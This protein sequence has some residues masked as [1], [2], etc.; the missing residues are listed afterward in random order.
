M[1]RVLGIAQCSAGGGLGF[2]LSGSGLIFTTYTVK[3]YYSSGVSLSAN[4]WQHI[5]AV[6]GA[7]NSV[8]FYVNGIEQ[9]TIAGVTPGKVCLGDI[10]IG[11]S[12]AAT[13]SPGQWF[14]GSIDEVQVFNRALTS[15]EILALAQKQNAGIQ[16]LEVAYIS[17][18]P[19]STQNNTQILP[20]TQLYLPFDDTEDAAGNLTFLDIS[21]QGFSGTCAQPGC[22]AVGQM[23]HAGSAAMFDGN[24]SVTIQA[25]SGSTDFM[26]VSAWIYPVGSEAYR[27]TFIAR[28]NHWSINCL[29][30]GTIRMWFN[31]TAL[32]N[33]YVYPG[34][35][36]P[37]NEWTHLVVVYDAGVLKTYANGK[38]VGNTITTSGSINNADW[39]YLGGW[40]AA[41]EYF[42]GGLDEVQVLTDALTDAQVE[43]LYLGSEAVVHLPLDETWAVSGSAIADTSGW[44]REGALSTGTADTANKAVE[45]VVGIG[46]VHLDGIDDYITLGDVNEADGLGDFALSQWFY[47]DAFSPSGVGW[48]APL[49]KGA[50]NG[51][52]GWAVLVNNIAG[53]PDN[54]SINLYLNGA[55]AST[56]P[57]P[58]GG[59]QIGR[60]YHYVFTRSGSTIK[61]Y[62]DGKE[63]VSSVSAVIPVANNAP[64]L[65]GKN[66]TGQYL[67][68]GKL[69]DLQIYRRGIAPEEA[70]ALYDNRW[71]NVT[72]S[73]SGNQVM[74]TTWSTML[75]P[76]LEGHYQVE[77]KSADLHNNHLERLSTWDGVLDT[78]DPRAVLTY[79][80][81]PTT[82]TLRFEVQ[83]WNL[84]E[85]TLL[86]DCPASTPFNKTFFN[87]PWYR[88]LTGVTTLNS[89]RLFSLDGSC[90]VTLSDPEQAS[91]TACDLF[92]NCTTVNASAATATAQAAAKT[93]AS[94]T[95]HVLILNPAPGAIVNNLQPLVITG[96]ARA[97]ASLKRLVITVDDT[98]VRSLKWDQ[99]TMQTYDWSAEWTPTTPG[100]HLVTAT[101]LDWA[102]AVTTHTARFILDV[103]APDLVISTSVLSTADV[104][105]NQLPIRGTATDENGIAMVEVKVQSEGYSS[106]WMPAA[107]E[108]DAWQALVYPGHDFH[109]DND[110]LAVQVRATDRSGIRRLISKDV[111]ADL[112][113]PLASDLAITYED[114]SDTYPL[115]RTGTTITSSAPILH[116]RWS[117]S[118]DAAGLAEYRAGWVIRDT[119]GVVDTTQKFKPGDDRLAS[120]QAGEAQELIAGVATTDQHGNQH[121]QYFGPV[122]VDSP[123]TPDYVRLD[124]LGGVYHGWMDSGCSLLGQDRRVNEVQ[125]DTATRGKNQALYATWDSRALRIAWTGANWSGDGDLF[126]Y[127]D[128]TTGGTLDVMDPYTTT[129]KTLHLPGVLPDGPRPDA[130]YADYVV[131]V[132]DYQTA[133]LYRWDGAAWVAASQLDASQFRLDPGLNGGTTDLYLPFELLGIIDPESTALKLVAFATDEAS[134]Q[135]W[136]VLP[137]SNPVT[138]EFVVG[139][140]MVEEGY[141]RFALN[142]PFSW[143]GL[144][145]GVCP[146]GSQA[147]MPNQRQYTD[148]NLQL[149]LTADPAGASYRYLGDH[150]FG[151]WLSLLGDKPAEFSS[152][153]ARISNEQRRVQD[154]QEISYTIHYTNKGS[155]AAQ[156]VLLQVR[157]RL[158][159]TLPDGAPDG[160]PQTSG[161]HVYLQEIYLGDIAPGQTGTV[162]VRGKVD[163]DWGEQAY[164]DCLVQHPDHPLACAF[165]KRWALLS[166]QV[167]DQAHT[168]ASGP[169]ELM[170]MDH[171]VNSTAP[172]FAGIANTAYGIS[173]LRNN[174]LQGYAF[175]ESGVANIKLEIAAPD[176]T[177]TQQD[178]QDPTPLDGQWQCSLNLGQAA[179]DGEEYRIRLKARDTI[180]QEGEWTPWQTFIVDHTGPQVEVGDLPTQ[181]PVGPPISLGLLNLKGLVHDNVGVNGVEVC[182][183][184]Q[185]QRVVTQLA[186]RDWGYADTVSSPL[187]I[188]VCG[189]GT[190]ERSFSVPEEYTVG[191]IRLGFQAEIANRDGLVLKLTSPSGLSWQL[192]GDDYDLSTNLCQSERDPE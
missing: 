69:D 97:E 80:G 53:I 124:N 140:T 100:N 148:D 74:S 52:Y 33:G 181:I 134:L 64:I 129:T 63:K 38:H 58:S 166:V 178:C 34:Y 111:T 108:G 103:Q 50:W 146:N 145:S 56:I 177:T 60:W 70:Q 83:D 139:R 123:L 188:G 104:V 130:M 189:S 192:T 18:L 107:L 161:E 143:D 153:L 167:F 79:E 46:A 25:G 191:D 49:G 94:S 102:N 54:H 14:Q 8:T 90:E 133:W 120:Y 131:W 110:L 35:Q 36:A 76:G 99:P 85:K 5:A 112:Q 55:I 126:V 72:L 78:T 137:Q 122:Y 176:G 40:P 42:G 59:W 96:S 91:L 15:A 106:D 16:S 113:A 185:C 127:L 117:E 101:L 187:A 150:L 138:S 7:D 144:G 136:A 164:Q 26:T 66:Q 190:L 17:D 163:L 158:A 116:L 160:E 114:F 172:L 37:L 93:L 11:R 121:S 149:S 180:G 45:G 132:Q 109:P 71:Q 73:S 77:F 142:H 155:Q 29:Q 135:I 23:G 41:G 175:D 27:G 6:M 154:S 61:G 19:G 115:T 82:Y 21:G 44:W 98:I 156:D 183:G 57:A 51:S 68:K 182:Q 162:T 48:S 152:I 128:T 9:Q 141:V 28:R 13:G 157:S 170:W 105:V 118:S 62:L 119:N 32:G 184:S 30:D 81:G 39:L 151:W 20:N 89:T 179:Q 67:W 43:A 92:G 22:P 65:L 75:P 159:L 4:Q 169:R 88:A 84:D 24:N 174:I 87:P 1:Q 168:P 165:N 186:A 31:D 12:I 95:D 173:G 125:P 3:D 86:T 171:R 2:G 10:Q 147:L 47:L